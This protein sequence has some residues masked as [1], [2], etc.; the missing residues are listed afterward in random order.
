[1]MDT[2]GDREINLEEFELVRIQINFLKYLCM[3]F[4]LFIILLFK[5]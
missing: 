3:F 5:L 1:M 2:N 4:S